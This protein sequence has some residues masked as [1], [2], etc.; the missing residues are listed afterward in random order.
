MWAKRRL[1][2]LAAG[3]LAGIALLG[4]SAAAL[5]TLLRSESFPLRTVELDGAAGQLTRAQVE[6]ALRGRLGGNFFA[7]DI[8]ALRAAVEGL[9]WV[10]RA[11][12]RRV[13]PDRLAVAVDEHVPL[14]R[15][16]DGGLLNTYGE[17]FSGR[18]DAPL[19]LLAGPPGTEAEV[20]RQYLRFA[21]VLAPLGAPLER[22]VLTPRFAWQLRLASGLHLMLGRDAGA[23]EGRLRRFV[24]IYPALEAK[25][26]HQYVDLRYPNGFALRLAE[27]RS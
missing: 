17:R 2:S 1:L 10:R 21:A 13:W 18:V 22:V 6:A 14:A 8:G 11:T 19:P 7:A 15:W 23:A 27:P 24:A 4:L 16:G 26:H 5:H 25:Q 12:V 3:F 9:P 20:A